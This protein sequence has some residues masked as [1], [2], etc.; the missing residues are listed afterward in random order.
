MIKSF[1][2]QCAIRAAKAKTTRHH[3]V[4]F[5]VI[6]VF[7]HNRKPI[8]RRIKFRDVGYNKILKPTSQRSFSKQVITE[9]AFS[10]VT[11]FMI[12]NFE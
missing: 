4:E 10:G 11:C 5:G 8:H 3:C 12:F 7:T 9:Y 1:K 6:N 2:N